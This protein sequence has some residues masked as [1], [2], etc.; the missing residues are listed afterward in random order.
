MPSQPALNELLAEIHDPDLRARLRTELQRRGAFRSF[1]LTFEDS[2]EEIDLVGK[3][4]VKGDRVQFRHALSDRTRYVV[5]AIVKDTAVVDRLEDDWSTRTGDMR[6]VPLKQLLVNV[7]HDTKVYPALRYAGG[8]GSE[9]QPRPSHMAIQGENLHVLQALSYTHRASVDL[10]L[11]DPPYNTGSGDWI[12]N[13]KYIGAD[14]AFR[15]SKWLAFMQRRLKIARDLLK[16]TGVIIV[17]IG[18]DEHHHLR[19]LMDQVFGSTNFIANVVWQGGGSALARHHAGGADYMLIYGRRAEL[20]GKLLD[21]KPYVPEMLKLVRDALDSGEST[22]SAQ[23]QLREFIKANEKGM[24]EGVTRFNNVDDQ[25]RIFETADLTNRLPRP[26]LRYPV[27]DP[28]TGRIYEPPANGWTVKRELMDEW[29]DAGL[30]AFGKRPRKKKSLTDYAVNM[31]VPTF[32]H[33]RNTANAHLEGIFGDK[34]F[35][36]PKDHRVLSRWIRMTAPKDA[37]VLD[38]FGGS[39]ST[40]EAV[41]RLNAEDGG[42]RQCIA[43]TSNEVGPKVARDLAKQGFAPGDPEWESK[44]VFQHVLRPRITTIVDGTRPDGSAYDNVV[45]ASVD[46]VSQRVEF[47]DLTWISKNRVRLGYDFELLAPLL[48]ARAGAYDTVPSA[49]GLVS[50]PYLISMSFAALFDTDRAAD[51]VRRLDGKQRV[52]FIVTDSD[53]AYQSAATQF[54]DKETRQL[55]TDYLGE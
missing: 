11:I 13:D 23:A 28:A 22:E 12:Y 40:L 30:I 26:N 34:R 51:L 21:P 15:H 2:A 29:V 16:P 7:D 8:I 17:H 52:V 54:P 6:R 25:G 1:G 20:V 5:D 19:M 50:D 18:D 46:N 24:P 48:W 38:F 32:Y 14:D 55:Y 33:S 39:G 3:A 41:L 44:G 37:V 53:T 47:F 43:A 42:T 4:P 27:T 49:P 31:P 35:P 45:P 36:F 9:R 10:I